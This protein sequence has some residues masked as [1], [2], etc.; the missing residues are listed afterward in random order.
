M[1]I[2]LNG[3]SDPDSVKFN[4]SYLTEVI[5]NGTTVWEKFPPTI[6]GFSFTIT[7]SGTQTLSITASTLTRTSV[8]QASSSP[9][10]RATYTGTVSG[11]VYTGYTGIYTNMNKRYIELGTPGTTQYSPTPHD[12]EIYEID[13]PITLNMR[14]SSSGTQSVQ[15]DYLKYNYSYQQ[16]RREF[17]QHTAFDTLFWTFPN[18]SMSFTASITVTYNA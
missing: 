3:G 15:F 12:I 18:D 9:Y 13:L 11:T 5:Y 6:S 8:Y 2:L 4:G 7:D 14:D 17:R 16:V 10:R 1:T